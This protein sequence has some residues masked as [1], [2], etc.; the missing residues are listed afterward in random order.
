MGNDII[1]GL[2][3]QIFFGEMTFTP[4]AGFVR[5]NPTQYDY[6]YGNKLKF[7]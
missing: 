7:V 5:F 2:E 3:G 4:S 6:E 1:S